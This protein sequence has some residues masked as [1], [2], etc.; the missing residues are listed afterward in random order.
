MLFQYSV[1]NDWFY[2]S[3]IHR[4]RHIVNLISEFAMKIGKKNMFTY[5]DVLE[6]IRR[7]LFQ[8]K[9]LLE[10]S[11]SVFRFTVSCLRNYV[12]Y[13]GILPNCQ[14]PYKS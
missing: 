4:M 9:I 5:A 6:R 10:H 12:G 8:N 3:K 2:V 13:F 14:T 1:T 11:K 7:Y